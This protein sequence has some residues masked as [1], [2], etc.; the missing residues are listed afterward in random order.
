VA[1][2]VIGLMLLYELWS[3]WRRKDPEPEPARPKKGMKNGKRR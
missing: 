2:I 1:A 3:W